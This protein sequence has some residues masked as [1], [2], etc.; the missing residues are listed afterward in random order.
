MRT[1]DLCPRFAAARR[2]AR[3]SWP[4]AERSH[5]PNAFDAR[6]QRKAYVIGSRRCK[7]QRVRRSTLAALP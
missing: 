3:R 6:K 4:G 7:A 5:Y 1:N 2:A